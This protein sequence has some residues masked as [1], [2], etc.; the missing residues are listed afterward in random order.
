MNRRVK[1]ARLH[2]LVERVHG[3]FVAEA[4]TSFDFAT[5]NA[6]QG[7][8]LREAGK[9]IVVMTVVIENNH[10]RVLHLVANPDKLTRV[11]R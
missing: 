2:D 5:V 7:L 3:R 10:I 6:S 9:P 8:I 11:D 1:L 4:E